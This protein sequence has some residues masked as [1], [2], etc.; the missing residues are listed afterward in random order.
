MGSGA[1]VTESG[2]SVRS[3]RSMLVKSRQRENRPCRAAARTHTVT[4]L[5]S[6]F[7]AGGFWVAGSSSVHGDVDSGFDVSFVWSLEFHILALLSMLAS[8]FGQLAAC[9]DPGS[10]PEGRGLLI[11]SGSV[12]SP[13]TGSWDQVTCNLEQ[14]TL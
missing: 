6:A 9:S 10:P 7:P 11:H 14:V 4:G 13:G 8:L 2:L 5:S 3:Q 12:S 1:A